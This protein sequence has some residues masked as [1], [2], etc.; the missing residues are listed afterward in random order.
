MLKNHIMD[1]ENSPPRP[2]MSN[3]SNSS[4]RQTN[5]GNASFHAQPAPL[6]SNDDM[7]YNGR[8]SPQTNSS[9][10]N[11]M[12]GGNF[13]N[14]NNSYNNYNNYNSYGQSSFNP[15]MEN[16][17]NEPP[18]LEELEIN[19]DHIWSKTQAVMFVNKVEGYIVC[20]LL[21]LFCNSFISSCRQS[22]STFLMM[23]I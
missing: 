22:A 14:F 16:F 8:D 17:D 11:N 18:L 4:G 7:W 5:N 12:M 20:F 3:F 19:F 6:G 23:Q 15:N 1:P 9:P 21:L 10:M 13:N 2:G